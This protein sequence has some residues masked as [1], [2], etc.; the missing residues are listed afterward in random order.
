MTKKWYSP[1]D[2]A[3]LLSVSSSTLR[4]WASLFADALSPT[5]AKPPSLAG[6]RL[7][8]RLYTDSDIAV[9][10]KASDLL[11]DGLS[12]EQ[13]MATLQIGGAAASKQETIQTTDATKPATQPTAVV[14]FAEL[15]T[16]LQ[17]IADQKQRLDRIETRL[18]ELEKRLADEYALITDHLFLWQSRRNGRWNRYLVWREGGTVF[19]FY[20]GP[21]TEQEVKHWQEHVQGLY[22]ESKLEP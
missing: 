15:T 16:A 12:Y 14:P 18:T 13:V 1:K 20:L 6:G 2:V 11:R 8:G 19:R 22:I 17:A 4:S 3:Q 10:R 9:L 5:A 7:G 21:A